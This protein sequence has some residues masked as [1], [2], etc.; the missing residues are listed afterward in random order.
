MSKR[1]EQK[2]KE[3]LKRHRKREKKRAEQSSLP[4]GLPQFGGELVQQLMDP[5]KLTT[6]DGIDENVKAFCRSINDTH[7]AVPLSCEP[8]KWSRLGCCNLNVNEYRK[9]NGGKMVSGYQI[10]YNSPIY[11]EGERHA[12]WSDD[13]GNLRNV[14]FCP[15][16]EATILFVPDKDSQTPFI[17]PP[18][19]LRDILAPELQSF[20]PMLEMADQMHTALPDEDA[21]AQMETYEQFL[22]RT[23]RSGA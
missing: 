3:L 14:S 1:S 22:A 9:I 18:K 16:G 19:K 5:T 23:N 8:E 13:D 12:V 11:I 7:D 15:D 21:W 20:L 4:A 6:P 2:R 10:W 17:G